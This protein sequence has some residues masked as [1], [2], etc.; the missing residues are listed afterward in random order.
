MN[1]ENGRTFRK[2]NGNRVFIR[3]TIGLVLVFAIASA[4]AIYF[5]QESQMERIRLRQETL[6]SELD[7]A[8][9]AQADLQDL[10]NMV[11]TDE[12]IERV[13][14]DK[15]GMVKPNEVIFGD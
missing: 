11:D 9:I 2:H 7:N 13:A 5:Q 8:Q 6:A 1:A 15:L 4:V 3:I 12:Y 10:Q 14:R